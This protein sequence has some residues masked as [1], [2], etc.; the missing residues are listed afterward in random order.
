MGHQCMLHGPST[1]G[2]YTM[3]GI[4]AKVLQGVTIG[5]GVILG[6]GAVANRDIP[7][8]VMALGIPAKVKK[9]IAESGKDGTKKN[10]LFYV[11][12]GKKFRFAGMNHPGIED[13]Y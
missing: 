5:D 6:S 2:S 8:N 10:A 1:I 3:I 9:E 12:N 7:D 13:F 4:G 11:E